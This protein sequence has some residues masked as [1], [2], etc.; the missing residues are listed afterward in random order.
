MVV[1]SSC[2]IEGKFAFR[3]KLD[4]TTKKKISCRDVAPLRLSLAQVIGHAETLQ[5]MFLRLVFWVSWPV[6]WI[7]LHVVS[8]RLERCVCPHYVIVES[9]LPREGLQ[10]HFV[11]AAGDSGFV[12]ANDGRTAT[13]PLVGPRSGV[14]LKEA[15]YRLRESENI[16]AAHQSQQWRGCDSA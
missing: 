7:P 16:G 8:D 5:A 12:R 9:R 4:F 3:I 2:G 1:G 11:A 6:G 13:L 10:S 14:C 15:R